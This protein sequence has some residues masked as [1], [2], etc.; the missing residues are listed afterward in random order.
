M[1]SSAIGQSLGQVEGERSNRPD[2]N[3]TDN[4]EQEMCKG[5]RYGGDIVGNQWGKYGRD[6]GAD[7]RS[8]G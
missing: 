2:N 7:I 4:I 1:F 3:D 5:N 8:Q 6:C